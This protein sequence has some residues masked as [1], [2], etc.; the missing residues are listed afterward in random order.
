MNGLASLIPLVVIWGL[1]AMGWARM[2]RQLPK[3]SV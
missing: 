3:I 1:A 2:R